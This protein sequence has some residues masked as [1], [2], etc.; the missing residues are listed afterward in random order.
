MIFCRQESPK[1]KDNQS[2]EDLICFI[3]SPKNP[4]PSPIGR[5]CFLSAPLRPGLGPHPCQ[6]VGP[7]QKH[8][9]SSLGRA[10]TFSAAFLTSRAPNARRWD[11]KSWELR[12]SLVPETSVDRREGR[13]RREGGAEGVIPGTSILS[14]EP[15]IL[16]VISPFWRILLDRKE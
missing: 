8:K 7:K 3:K 12:E 2:M 10:P 9:R 16:H 14:S 13:E 15:E 6:E 4:G 11:E 1:R 5:V